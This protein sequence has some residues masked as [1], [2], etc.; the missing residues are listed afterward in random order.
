M[1]INNRKDI[2]IPKLQRGMDRIKERIYETVGRLSVSFYRTDEP[3]EWKDREEGI[4]KPIGVGEKWGDLFD[5]A[6][7]RMV[8]VVPAAAAG[9]KVVFVIDIDGEGCLF[10]DAGTPIRGITNISSDFD[11]RLGL[12]GKR[13]LQ[14]SDRA[15]GGERVDIW[16]DAGCNDLFGNMCGGTLRQAEIAVCDEEIRALYYD[17]WVLFDLL[18]AIDDSGAR[19]H[20]ALYALEKVSNTINRFTPEEV[21]FCRGVLAVQLGMKAA[22]TGLVF[23]ASGQAHLDL[24]WLWPI[25]ETK[26]KAARTFSTALELL[27]RYPDYIFGASQ[28]QQY[29]WIKES[30]PALYKKIKAQVEA[31]RIEP[32]GAMWVEPDLNLTS[33]ESLARQVMYG[34]R[35]FEEEFGRTVDI[36]HIPDVFG[37][38]AALPQI[39]KKS[40]VDKLLT[41]K[42]SWNKYNKFPYHSFR[43]RGIDGSEVFVH[44]PPEGVYNSAMAPRSLCAAEKNFEEK[45][46]AG[47]AI[48]MYGIGDGGG[49]PG[50]EHLERLKRVKDLSGVSRVKSADTAK[51]FDEAVKAAERLPVYD[52]E[53]YL[54]KHQG[55][56]T[57][58][59]RNKFFNRRMELALKDAEYFSVM[60]W[61]KK[62]LAYPKAQ[63]EA[64]WKEVLLYQ[65]HDILPGS[66]IKRVYDE[67]IERY[68]KLLKETEEISE[69][70]LAALGGGD[71]L[72]NPNSFPVLGIPAYSSKDALKASAGLT[73]DRDGLES[74]TV[75]V[76]FD[77]NGGVKELFD[78]RANRNIL[79][80]VSNIFALYRDRGDAWDMEDGWQD[81]FRGTFRL[82]S[83]ESAVENGYAVRR[84]RFAFGDSV[85]DQTV[86]ISNDSAMTDF[87]CRIDWRERGLFLKVAFSPDVET[88][89]I[90]CGCAYGNIKR[91]LIKNNPYEQAQDEIS[92]H[93]YVD[94]SEPDYGVAVFND[95]KYGCS[96]GKR[97][98]K[99]S[100]LR[101]VEWPGRDADRGVHT[102][103]F[104]IYPHEGAFEHSDVAEAS[105]AYQ[106]RLYG[107]DAEGLLAL[108]NPDGAIVESIKAAENGKGVVV[109]ICEEKGKR[110]A[111][112][113]KPNFSYQKSFLISIDERKLCETDGLDFTLAPF[114]ILTLLFED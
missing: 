110:A 87:G 74:D 78:K 17:Y 13:V 85:I 46:L 3:V 1:H 31:G 93:R 104:A 84:Q 37:F 22:D 111:V 72:H 52:G 45:G 12:P 11:K 32:Q 19:Y 49:G 86:K 43:W 100:V 61:K 6:W 54:E 65:F 42:L 60:A 101:S 33:G 95:C 36:A 91:S 112:T 14:F 79:C 34:K 44:M 28:P 69:R 4:Y 89:R 50:P 63:F 75:R 90:N 47:E 40:G 102:F 7:F 98:L 25:R 73:A 114:E 97:D 29:A 106:T 109:R 57:S 70:A 27:K 59:A 24:A 108:V 105:Y 10:D 92:M 99:I 41:I 2:L 21:A 88:D 58:Q 103:K 81:R 62:G 15:Q 82:V 30:H 96:A 35:F 71:K 76:I 18:N 77:E 39:L 5:C 55:T 20:S 38:N 66:S 83:A 68:E 64:V 94:M 56:Y 8:G 26:R 67:S 53:M 51:F 16:I 113:V 9:K 80:G 48:L 23:Y 107:L